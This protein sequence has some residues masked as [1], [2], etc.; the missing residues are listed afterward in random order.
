MHDNE[1][2]KKPWRGGGGDPVPL[3]RCAFIL[4]GLNLGTAEVNT[5]FNNKNVGNRRTI[6]ILPKQSRFRG[7]FEVI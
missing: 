7:G 1:I 4:S 5:G 6:T 2:G 3:S